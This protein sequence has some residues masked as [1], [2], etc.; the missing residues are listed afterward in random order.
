MY[1]FPQSRKALK[2][3]KERFRWVANGQTQFS[4][5]ISK[6]PCPFPKDGFQPENR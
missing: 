3:F 5:L 4:I 6:T 2:Q 1:F